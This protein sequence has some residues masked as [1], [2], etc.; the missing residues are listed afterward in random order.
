M[1]PWVGE[2]QE[3]GLGLSPA[4][5]RQSFPDLRAFSSTGAIG[6]A[7]SVVL[8]PADTHLEAVARAGRYTFTAGELAMGPGTLTLAWLRGQRVVAPS[9]VCSVSTP[10]TPTAPYSCCRSY[11]WPRHLCQCPG[12]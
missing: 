6:S 11:V 8:N 10:P 9:F 1:G 12:P 4:V 7:Y 3:V 2:Q 5:S